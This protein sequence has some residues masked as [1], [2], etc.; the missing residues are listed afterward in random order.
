MGIRPFEIRI[1]LYSII[2]ALYIEF[3]T[4]EGGGLQEPEIR[5]ERDVCG[6]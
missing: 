1:I 2:D 6:D 4:P 5:I 3:M